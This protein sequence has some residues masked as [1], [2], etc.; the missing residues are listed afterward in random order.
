MFD[1]ITKYF[2]YNRNVQELAR[3]SDR[4]LKDIGISRG[5]IRHIARRK[6]FN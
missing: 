5:E 6:V 1:A 4:E 3:L 2:R